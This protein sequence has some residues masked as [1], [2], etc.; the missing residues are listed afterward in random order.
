MPREQGLPLIARQSIMDSRLNVVAYELLYRDA[1]GGNASRTDPV[2]ATSSVLVDALL[3][4]GLERLSGGLPVHVNFPARMLE[5]VP[6]LVLRPSQMVIEVLEDTEGSDE[7][8]QQLRQL[9]MRGYRVALDDY[10]PG[11]ADDRLL[12]CVD[13]VKL[14]LAHLSTAEACRVA[15]GL[16]R[17]LALTCIAEKVE[18]REQFEACAAAGIELH[19]GYF[20]QRPETFVDKRGSVDL[21]AAMR[22]LACLQR[23]DSTAREIE[24]LIA[25][26]ASLAWR[27]LRAVQCARLYLP[28]RIDNL[29]QA[30]TVLGRDYLTRIV[31][32]LLLCRCRDRPRELMRNALL[33]ARMAELLALAAGIEGSSAHFMAGLLSLVPPMLGRPA[34]EVFEDL[35]LSPEI[36]RGVLHGDGPIGESLACIRA[37]ERAE[38]HDVRFRDLSVADIRSTYL[39][40]CAWVEDFTPL[41][42]Q[43]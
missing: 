22:I 7:V 34:A 13:I 38:W 21:G 32:M 24:Q 43:P 36:A 15:A 8:L 4:L 35:P 30:V 29:A 25:A 33:R 19:Q 10:V 31:A 28:R 2:M 20:L 42:A 16:R 9:R 39:D 1:S 37:L 17:R 3:E 26:D 14:D 12:D 18:T 5:Q 6:S 27:V 41:V 11:L 23:Q 40:A